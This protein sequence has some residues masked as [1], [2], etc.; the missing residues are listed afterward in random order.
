MKGVRLG[1]RQKGTPNKST[2]EAE[3][4]CKR[5]GCDPFEILI[6]FA[7]GDYR[8]LGYSFEALTPELRQK[9]AA[10]A[11]RYLRPQRKA[12]EHTT[13]EEGFKIVIEDYQS[14]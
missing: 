7:K 12:V 3:A 10:E 14:K 8:T 4:I 9:S 1:G 5:L 6:L 2:T 13:G 11:V